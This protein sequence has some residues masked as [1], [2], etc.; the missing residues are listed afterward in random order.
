MIPGGEMVEVMPSCVAASARRHT[1]LWPDGDGGQ[2]CLRES[3]IG[4]GESGNE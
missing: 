3:G 1:N 4:N 2:T